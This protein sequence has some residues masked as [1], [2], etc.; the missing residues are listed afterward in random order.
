MK[1]QPVVVALLVALAAVTAGAAAGAVA[2][3]DAVATST[4][5][6]AGA[7]AK[8]ANVS[9]ASNASLGASISSFMQASEAEADATVDSGLFAAKL[10]DTNA[11]ERAHLVQQRV[12]QLDRRLAELEEEREAFNA[13]E[14]G[15]VRVAERA[16]AAELAVRANS[17][18][19]AANRTEAA[20]ERAGV[21][22][23][24]TKL[25][26]LRQDARNMTG[27]EV[28][29]VATGLVDIDRR[30]PPEDRPGANQG[31]QDPPG[32]ADN[33]TGNAS[34]G[35]PD[36]PPG[37]DRGD[38]GNGDPPDDPPGNDGADG[39]DGSGGSGDGSDGS[40]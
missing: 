29:A 4:S 32:Q 39:R 17:L 14:D 19:S 28:A 16:K 6:P 3:D 22:V 27:Q 9:N 40:P 1:T 20:A 35:Q 10:N 38:S 13:T 15:T 12:D 7:A 31:Q 24:E 26:V 21:P 11:S 5:A 34:D 37:S 8:T 33:R 25:D 18:V 23:N 30:G 2:S 36:E